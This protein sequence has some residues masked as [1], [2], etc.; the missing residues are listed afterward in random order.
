MPTSNDGA[1]YD[2]MYDATRLV[3][4]FWSRTLLAITLGV[5]LSKFPA[6]EAIWGAADAIADLLNGFRRHM[7][8]DQIKAARA[9]L[10]W[11]REKL[12]AESGAGESTIRIFEKTGRVQLIKDIAARG[13]RLIAIRTAL[14]VAGV[15]FIEG[16]QPGVKLRAR[17]VD[18]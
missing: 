5:M 13:D 7:T 16:D 10:G 17:H 2:Q 14:E 15:E 12:G 1:D 18:E 9:L 4:Q 6:N 3:A 8:P 11:S